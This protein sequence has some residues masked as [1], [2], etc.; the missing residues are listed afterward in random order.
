[1]Q[2]SPRIDE[3]ESRQQHIWVRQINGTW[4]AFVHVKE[5]RTQ[6]RLVVSREDPDG[7]TDVHCFTA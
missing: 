4:Y 5:S 7:W 2:I 3:S 1:M 6:P